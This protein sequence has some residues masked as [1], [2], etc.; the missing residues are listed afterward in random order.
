MMATH[1]NETVNR[2][3]RLVIELDRGRI[4]RDEDRAGYEVQR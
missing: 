2:M 1:D 3:R 4:V